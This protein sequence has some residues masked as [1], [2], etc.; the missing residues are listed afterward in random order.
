MRKIL[1]VLV[2]LT[3]AGCVHLEHDFTI[4]ITGSAGL[5]FSGAYMLVAT[6]GNN[7][8]K[9]VDGKVP[10]TFSLRG[11]LVSCSFQKKFESGTLR[12]EIL[13]DG[14]AVSQSD[15]SA[16]YGVVSLAAQ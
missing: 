4:R 3:I 16:A 14:V 15:T 5:P 6:T 7:L 10:E 13:K 2:F 1:L 9:S 11:T 8:S 12:I